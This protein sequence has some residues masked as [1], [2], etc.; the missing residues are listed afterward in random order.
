[1]NFKVASHYE[2]PDN[3]CGFKM[4]MAN[5]KFI[6]DAWDLSTSLQLDIK[7]LLE[8]TSG[9]R[10]QYSVLRFGFGVVFPKTAVSVRFRFSH[11]L[12]SSQ[13]STDALQR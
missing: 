5:V 10:F 7:P 1:M 11:L 12:F 13:P 9:L 4:S 6:Q 3:V 8:N 2:L